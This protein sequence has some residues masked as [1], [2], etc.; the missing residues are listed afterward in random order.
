MLSLIP[1]YFGD[2]MSKCNRVASCLFKKELAP[3]R[4]GRKFLEFNSSILS[5]LSKFGFS[6]CSI[7][8]HRRFMRPSPSGMKKRTNVITIGTLLSYVALK[9]CMTSPSYIKG[10]FV[11]DRCVWVWISFEPAVRCNV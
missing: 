10:L 7:Q 6:F 8:F 2:R 3:F 4:C 5:L 9:W 11:L 1:L